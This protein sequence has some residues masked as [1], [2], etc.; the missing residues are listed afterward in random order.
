MTSSHHILRPGGLITEKAYCATFST[1]IYRYFLQPDSPNAED[2]APQG[3][4]AVVRDAVATT[5]VDKHQ[6]TWGA[7]AAWAA[8]E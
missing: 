5:V 8:L 6:R 3:R 1:S 2:L 4:Q 7:L